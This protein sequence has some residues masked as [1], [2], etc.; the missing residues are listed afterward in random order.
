MLHTPSYNNN[1][2]WLEVMSWLANENPNDK[3]LT[4]PLPFTLFSNVK[5]FD[6]LIF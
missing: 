4:S 6:W 2:V 3:F 5:L 1:Q